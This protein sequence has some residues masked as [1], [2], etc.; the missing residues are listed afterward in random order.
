MRKPAKKLAGFWFLNLRLLLNLLVG[1]LG[2]IGNA[3]GVV[4]KLDGSVVEI[5]QNIGDT[6][7]LLK[8]VRVG[9]GVLITDN[10]V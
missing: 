7:K 5:G 3:S 10:V 2:R 6:L 1:L 4:S 9:V 8:V